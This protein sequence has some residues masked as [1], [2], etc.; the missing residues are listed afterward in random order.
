MRTQQT[1]NVRYAKHAYVT[2]C[3][4]RVT[5]VMT[6][7]TTRDMLNHVRMIFA[8]CDVRKT[9]IYNDMG[10]TIIAYADDRRATISDTTSRITYHLTNILDKRIDELNKRK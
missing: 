1:I 3:D 10:N 7:A 4:N 8:V 6:Y 5:N 9:R 2:L